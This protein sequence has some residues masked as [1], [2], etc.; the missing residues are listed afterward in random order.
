MVKIEAKELP[1][2]NMVLMAACCSKLDMPKHQ[3][4][5]LDHTEQAMVRNYTPFNVASEI[6]THVDALLIFFAF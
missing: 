4:L 5:Q 1:L 2:A 6:T 3:E